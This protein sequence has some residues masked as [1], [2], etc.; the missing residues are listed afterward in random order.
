MLKNDYG[1]KIGDYAI[2]LNRPDHTPYDEGK[3]V[4]VISMNVHEQ[5]YQVSTT[6]D[7]VATVQNPYIAESDCGYK[8]T[9]EE[10]ETSEFVHEAHIRPIDYGPKYTLDTV[11]FQRN[12]L[13]GI[14][15]ISL[16]SIG[17]FVAS[18]YRAIFGF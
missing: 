4:R 5:Q 14:N 11:K 10:F 16:I 7:S 18:R 6:L 15:I 2:V 1:I 8:L 17:I 3:L 13:L 12:L 9:K